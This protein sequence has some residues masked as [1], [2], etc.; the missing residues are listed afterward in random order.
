MPS[1]CWLN[2][3]KEIRAGT[4]ASIEM[5]SPERT[6]LVNVA[7]GDQ[8]GGGCLNIWEE[9]RQVDMDKALGASSSL[10][11]AGLEP[12]RQIPVEIQ[13]LDAISSEYGLMPDLVKLD[14]Q[15]HELAAIKGAASLL[16][17]TAV[18]VI[19]FG[20]LDSY[21]DRSSPRDLI[22]IMYDNGYLLYDIVDL[23]YC[24]YDNA[25]SGGD[26]FLIHASSKL[27]EHEALF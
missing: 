6:I 16:G 26:F 20:C 24:P 3:I 15:G 2:Q 12:S 7:I 5:M 22:D 8:V 18:F 25:L 1:F 9:P 10:S 21:V 11:Q 19:E 27:V 4:S 13:T 23:C 17:K 14:L